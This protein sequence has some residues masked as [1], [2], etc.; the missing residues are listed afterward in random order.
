MRCLFGIL[1][2]LVFLS[3]NLVVVLVGVR[4]SQSLSLQRLPTMVCFTDTNVSHPLSFN[5]RMHAH[6]NARARQCT[7]A[8]VLILRSCMLNTTQAKVQIA[9]ND[10]RTMAECFQLFDVVHKLTQN[11]ETVHLAAQQVLNGFAADNVSYLELRTT[12]RGNA[13]NG[14]TKRS[15]LESVLRAIGEAKECAIRSRQHRDEGDESVNGGNGGSVPT[16]SSPM[17]VRLLLSINRTGTKENAE[18]TVDLAA[19]YMPRGVVGT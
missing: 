10:Q 11:N 2:Y 8:H 14:M 17:I 3:G 18:D 5:Q 4:I 16:T 1:A 13:A 12:P 6:A 19:E 9:E 7:N 15:Y